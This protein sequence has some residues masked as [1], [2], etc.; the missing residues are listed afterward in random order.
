MHS[1]DSPLMSS[2]SHQIIGIKTSAQIQEQS[3]TL[4]IFT[5]PY[6][7]VVGEHLIAQSKISIK[8]KYLKL[9]L[10]LFLD[11]EMNFSIIKKNKQ[12]T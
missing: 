11:T 6:P 9:R 12:I 4:Y 10:Q 8:Q 3:C 2:K 7:A 5:L 1:K